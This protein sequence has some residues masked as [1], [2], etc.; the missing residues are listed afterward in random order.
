MKIA[1]HALLIFANVTLF[2]RIIPIVGAQIFRR[3]LGSVIALPE[4][5]KAESL[6][7]SA[8]SCEQRPRRFSTFAAPE[9]SAPHPY[10]R[11]SACHLT[12]RRIIQSRRTSDERH[13]SRKASCNRSEQQLGPDGR[14]RACNGGRCPSTIR[15]S[16]FSRT[17]QV[18]LSKTQGQ[19]KLHGILLQQGV[20][21]GR[22]KD[23][24]FRGTAAAGSPTSRCPASGGNRS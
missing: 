5:V 2:R 21:V 1:V 6:P 12:F 20:F 7:V 23:Q 19:R 4:G 3:D 18:R 11:R 9:A 24:P 13:R 22:R 8:S 17:P 10:G 15:R 16:T 14:R